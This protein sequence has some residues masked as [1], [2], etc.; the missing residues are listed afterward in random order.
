MRVRRRLPS[1]LDSV[2]WVLHDNTR[3]NQLLKFTSCYG[4]RNIQNIVRRVSPASTKPTSKP[5]KKN[6]IPDFVEVMACPS[7]CING[8]GQLK[9]EGGASSVDQRQL[10]IECEEVYT[11]ESVQGPEVNGGVKELLDD[12]IGEGSREVLHTGYHV[13]AK[14]DATEV[15]TN[16]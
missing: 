8:G 16:W 13:V 6:T 5:T 11:D 12:W 4:F 9:L 3:E 14:L 15:F 2:T 10:V 1:P 7:G